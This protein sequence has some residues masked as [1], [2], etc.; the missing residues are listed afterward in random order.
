MRVV[1]AAMALFASS[2]LFAAPA[3][4]QDSDPVASAAIAQGDY[5]GAEKTLLQE[6]RIHPG[7]PELMINLA[8]VY[9]KTGRKAEARAMFRQV[10]AQDDV[11]M[12]L[13]PDRTAGSHALA[14]AG[15]RRLDGSWRI[16]HDHTS[17]A[18]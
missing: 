16:V 13:S 14:V 12:D 11:L 9:A 3:Q 8:T 18:E 10:L 6:L 15:L 4:A 7:R 2:A 5:A 17:A 1:V